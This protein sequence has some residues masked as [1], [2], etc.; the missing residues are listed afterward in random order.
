M[1]L[2]S[3]LGLEHLWDNISVT[4]SHNPS[5]DAYSIFNIKFVSLHNYTPANA[6]YV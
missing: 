5:S 3:K 4:V 2:T 6:L 1:T